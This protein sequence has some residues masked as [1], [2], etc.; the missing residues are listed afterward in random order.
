[1]EPLVFAVMGAVNIACFLAGAWVGQKVHKGEPIAIKPPAA[2]IGETIRTH[3]ER[4]D[5]QKEQERLEAVLGNIERYDG[6][7]AGQREIPRR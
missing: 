2:G 6:T 1:M 5:M 3:R 7:G 4:K